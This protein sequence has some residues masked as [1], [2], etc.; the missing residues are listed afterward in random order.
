MSC[1]YM[2]LGSCDGATHSLSP[3]MFFPFT[4][5]GL[6]SPAALHFHKLSQICGARQFYK[7]KKKVEKLEGAREACVQVSLYFDII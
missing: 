3:L 4:V 2:M 7:T 5:I 6:N 1:W